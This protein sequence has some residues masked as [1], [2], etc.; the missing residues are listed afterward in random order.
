[1]T[2]GMDEGR[3]HGKFRIL[4]P[5]LFAIVMVV[6]ILLGLVLGSSS[7]ENKQSFFT[8]TQHEKIEEILNYISHRYVD[9][10]DKESLYHL[11]IGEIFKHL[12]P[13]SIYISADELARMNEPLQGHFE[14][15]GVE[16]FIVNDTIT[17]VTALPGGPSEKLGIKAGDK[18][19]Y[20]E[21]SL[22]AGVG[23]ESSSVVKKLK[24]PKGT[25]VKVEILR[26]SQQ[27]LIT[28][29]INRDAVKINSIDV[30]YILEND[31]GYIK[32]SRF[33][34][35]SHEDFLE[36]VKNLKKQGMTKLILDLRDNGGG[37]LEQATRLADEL[38]AGEGILVYTE[39]RSYP[40]KVFKGGKK[41]IFEEGELVVMINE[42]SA[43]ASEI[44]AG[45]IQDWE[46]GTIVGRRSYG[47]ALVQEEFLLNDGAG[48]RLT[49]ARYYTPKGRSIQRSYDAGIDAYHEDFMNRVLSEYEGQDSFPVSDSAVYGIN[50]EVYIHYDTTLPYKVVSRLVNQGIIPRFCYSY[51]SN[52][53]DLFKGY[54][55]FTQFNREF[56]VDDGLFNKFVSFS[57]AETD[58][59]TIAELKS[60][61]SHLSIAMKA[62]F[63]RQLFNYD[64]FYKVLNELDQEIEIAK[65]QF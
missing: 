45:A 18:I 7:K 20:I 57:S 16:F 61:K 10:V 4:Y 32:L 9:S 51:F 23:I 26:K 19:I 38:I 33:A 12:D 11:A 56:K 30:G 40:K 35:T 58:A 64:G 3:Q 62:F 6:G 50:P 63:A 15:I 8:R 1:M 5:V 2:E 36:I 43:S 17:V 27:E 49:V 54:S 53:P 29:N 46:R 41:G 14:G 48:M 42:N 59:V 47:K 52:N 34:H 25:Q 60:S 65:K 28:H 31:I 44:L 39:G 22:V 55:T 13:H 24:G 21:D 37:F